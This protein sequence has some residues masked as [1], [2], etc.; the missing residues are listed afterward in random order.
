MFEYWNYGIMGSGR[1]AKIQA[2]TNPCKF[3]LEDPGPAGVKFQRSS[4]GRVEE[5]PTKA[6]QFFSSFYFP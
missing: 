5:Q 1:L 6:T 3:N 2:S 4:T